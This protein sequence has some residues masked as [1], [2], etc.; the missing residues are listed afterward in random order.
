MS[1]D[2][3]EKSSFG[4][5]PIEGFYFTYLTQEWKWTSSRDNVSIDD[6]LYLPYYISRGKIK[7]EEDMFK[8]TVD[9]T[10]EATNDIALLF[11]SWIEGAILVTIWRT[12]Y[13][14]VEDRVIWKGRVVAC[15]FKGSEAVLKAETIY[16]NMRKKG[17]KRVFQRPCPYAIYDPTACKVDPDSYKTA[18]IITNIAG[19]IITINSSGHDTDYFKAGYF[20]TGTNRRL[21]L[22]SLSDS[23]TLQ[24]SISGIEIGDSCDVYAGCDKVYATCEDKFGDNTVN[25]GGFTHIPHINPFTST[26]YG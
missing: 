22:S 21:I 7:N 20:E 4:S 13:G 25:Y 18:T 14:D 1:F 19:N 10:V 15:D 9:I 3:L 23:V 17:L 5:I 2:A 8:T 24:S 6:E 12:H 16:T 26:L 11:R